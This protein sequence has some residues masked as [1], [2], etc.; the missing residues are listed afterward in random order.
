MA[1]IDAPRLGDIDIRFFSQ[2]KMDATQ[3]GRFINQ[4]EMQKSHRRADIIS[5]ERAI[6]ISFTQP[7]TPSRLELQVSCKLLDRQLSCMAQICNGLS[8]FLLG[9]EHL[10]ICATRPT[11]GQDVSDRREEW[12]RLT[13][14]FRGTKWFQVAGDHSKNIVLALQHYEIPGG[15]V[16]PALYKLCIREPD[17]RYAPLQEAVASFIQ[18]R[19]SRGDAIGVEYERLRVNK[20]RG[21]GTAFAR[22]SFLSRANVLGV[23]PISRQVTIDIFSD[24]V[25]LEI[26]HHHLHA[27][28]KLWHTLTHVCQKWRQIILASPL[29]LHLQLYC[30]YGTPVIETLGCLPPFPLVVSYGGSPLLDPPA[31]EDEENM[32]AALMQ[33]DRVRSISLT[34]TNSLLENIST[35]S[36]P[37]LELEE[38][39]LLS[40]D[41]GPLTLPCAFRSGPSLHTLHLTRAAVPALPGLLSSF[42]GLVDLQI[43]EIPNVGYFPPDTF[44]NALSEMTQ[45]RSLSLHFLSLP[46]RRNYLGLPPPSGE[47][48]VL[49]VLTRLKYRGTSKYLDSFVA[50]I[51]TPRL[52]DI[53]ITFFNQPTM[54]ASQLGRFIERIEIQASLSQADVQISAHSISIA[55]PNPSTDTTLRL[56]ISCKQLDWQLSSMTQ[57]CNHFPPFL[58][59]I[60]D[61]RISSTQLPNWEHS[62]AGEQWSELIRVFGSAKDLRVAGVHVTDILCALHPADG[63]HPTDPTVL[64]SLRNL[65]VQ[66]P[67]RPEMPLW[68]ASRSFIASRLLSGRPVEL[69]ASLSCHLCFRTT[70]F[71]TQQELKR[72]FVD[73]HLGRI[74]CS[75]CG[76]FECKPGHNDLFR[77]HLESKHP[78]AHNDTHISNPASQSSSSFSGSHGHGTQH[79][80][81][82]A[83]DIFGPFT[84]LLNIP[85]DPFDMTEMFTNPGGDFDFPGS[86]SDMEPWFEP[87]PPSAL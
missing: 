3:L 52:G 58:L 69:I 64:P 76:D 54:D 73:N 37:F 77:E 43:H 35:I 25:L 18:S 72:H 68:D 17:P 30:T 79:N 47:R 82:R 49:P 4:I 74:V 6:S 2:S 1:R 21:T 67:M 39:V 34:V 75:Y 16:L 45:L 80:D 71:T 38:L 8:A 56:Q 51:D 20:L 42:T 12:L 7:E 41:S 22:C 26:F 36:E 78:V 55:F 70:S 19:R 86:L 50:R 46:P 11:S 29:S 27:S 15:Y 28:P 87:P 13:R 63:D 23:G 10:R 61:L 60:E 44:A 66:E 84:K 48:V 40:R 9:V 53:D 32:M 14:P 33:S 31:P 24:D 85:E 83:S 65:H 57:I 59:H 81:L 5:S 62:M